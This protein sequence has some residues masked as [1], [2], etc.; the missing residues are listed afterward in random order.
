MRLR[1]YILASQVSKALSGRYLDEST[2]IWS[3]FLGSRYE[4]G[5]INA[6]FYPSGTLFV[7]YEIRP[8]PQDSNLGARSEG[9]K[10]P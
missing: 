3:R 2:V 1:T 9:F 6:R 5:F 8:Q 7:L 4:S 10:K